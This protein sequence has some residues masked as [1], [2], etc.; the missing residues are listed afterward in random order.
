[1]IKLRNAGAASVLALFLALAL[2]TTGA[3]AQSVQVSKNASDHTTHNRLGGGPV[4]AAPIAPVAPVMPAA[5]VVQ[6]A[7]PARQGVRWVNGTAIAVAQGANDCGLFDGFLTG[8]GAFGT[9]PFFSGFHS[10]GGGGF[11][12][13]NNGCLW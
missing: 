2:L 11:G 5:P 9:F 10:F 6:K 13:L 8:C 4:Q 12:I 1:M 7:A 3:F